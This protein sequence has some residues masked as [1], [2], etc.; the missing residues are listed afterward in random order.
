MDAKNPAD[1]GQPPSSAE[2]KPPVQGPPAVNEEAT[3]EAEQRAAAQQKEEKESPSPSNP[4]AGNDEDSR[5]KD[6]SE[7]VTREKTDKLSKALRDAA[8]ELKQPEKNE[9]LAADD[10]RQSPGD[11]P[12]KL[13]EQMPSPCR[14]ERWCE[15]S[16]PDPGGTPQD[17]RKEEN[18][19]PR[20]GDEVRNQE[21][22]DPTR[23][24]PRRL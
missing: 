11:A 16:K 14:A 19:E 7:K 4:Q 3:R 21:G 18:R 5:P 9:S 15:A 2:Q 1:A 24:S 22:A 13:R 12:T 17:S 23:A 10:K 6:A 8:K 20:Q